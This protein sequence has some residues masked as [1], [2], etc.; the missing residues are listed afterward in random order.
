[1]SL[2]ALCVAVSVASAMPQKENKPAAKPDFNREV[3]PILSQNCFK[4]HGPD[5]KQRAA[6]L[7]L[8]TP[9]GGKS[10]F[11]RGE[12]VRRILATDAAQMP[13]SHTN[14]ILT[15]TQKETLKRWVA[16]GAN[17][18]PHWAFVPPK[19]SAPNA[20][21]DG[22]VQAHMAREH[23][24]LSPEADRYT[25]VRRLSL[26]LIGLPPTPEETDAFVSDTSAG[27]YEKLVDRLLASP[28]YGEK[29]ARKWLDLARYADTNG[30][31]K[32]R[33]RTMYLYRD[34]VIN[35]LNADMP[36][37]QFTIKQLAGD[38]LS[39]ASMSDK[40]ATGFHRNTM[41]NEE[42]G[43]D[44]L[45]FRFYSM[46]DRVATTGTT[47]L[48][49]TVGCA[50]CH[51]HKF[52]PITHTD[53]YRFLALMNN[54]DEPE[55]EVESADNAKKRQEILAQIAMREADLPRRFPVPSTRVF[56]PLTPQS[57]VTTSG[58][59]LTIQSDGSLLASGNNPETDTYTVAL[60]APD[61]AKAISG[62]RLE[63][64]TDVSLGKSGPGRTPHGNFVLTEI[65]GEVN[66]VA[67][68]LVRA[69]ADF[70][71]EGFLPAG[72][73]DKSKN[74]G[75]AISG[76]G[77]WNVN[78]TAL[79]FFDTPLVV[80]G[81]AKITL[82]LA[83]EYGGQH[84]LGK[85]RLSFIEEQ[86]DDAQPIETQRREAFENTFAAWKTEKAKAATHW[87]VLKPT[88]ARS[89]IPHLTILPDHSVI[90]LGDMSKRDI[91]DVQFANV[92]K[93]ITA[94]RLEAL[95]D[96]R[97][98]KGGPG[99]IFY[100]GTP[101]NFI[102]SELTLETGGKPLPFSRAV[103]TTGN[104]MSAMDNN[105]LTGWSAG[106]DSGQAQVA[107]FRLKEPLATDSFAL[108]M[109]FEFYY[110][111]GLG[112]FRV[113]V[114]TDKSN[115]IAA[116]P[117]QVETLLALPVGKLTVGQD[118]ELRR[119]FCQTTPTLQ[120]EREAI[121]ALRQT[122]PSN[123]TALVFS[124]RP[125]DNPRTTFRQHRGEFLQPKERVTPATFSFL[126]N[127]AATTNRLAFARWLVS[128]QNPLTAR[129]IVNRQWAAFFGRG[130]VP[131]ENDFGYQGD[132]PSHPELLDYL[133][134]R[135]QTPVSQSGQAGLG[136]S[137]KK[138]HKEI[139][140]S[141]TYKQASRSTP[142]A[143]KSDPKN[144]LLARGPRVRLDA[145]LIRDSALKASGLLS[146][147]RGGPSV[148]PPQKPNITTEGAYGPLTWTVSTGEDRYRRGLYT[149][150]KRTAP[151]AMF[152]TFD[153]GSGEA[154]LARRDVSNT[155]LQALT[156]LNNEV[157]VEA[158]QALGKSVSQ[159]AGT[160]S[161]KTTYLFRRVL[162]R[163][164]TLA[165]IAQLTAFYNTQLARLEKKE[166]SAK[167]L[168]GTDD[169]K[170]AAWTTLARA[171]LNLDEAIVKR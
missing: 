69:E 110:A 45:E 34:W 85:F 19:P 168:C 117:A 97:L 124:E 127:P 8:D 137:L 120:T 37:D 150:A 20:S 94:I 149:F 101:G 114:T 109:L 26:D 142:S 55:I 58:A 160:D 96:A 9:T 151:Y 32:D 16:S 46:T 61:G 70:S 49:L 105:P 122:I 100:E 107:V 76:A 3:R 106:G 40:I 89:E 170:Q 57:G 115:D 43:I 74:T 54:A 112:R 78:R 171:L 145:E 38:M 90:A 130:I 64:L 65:S 135:F 48:G 88:S 15:T 157:F 80:P 79:F 72:A 92:P 73:L 147:K 10:V 86:R 166:L 163:P 60:K 169:T 99:R 63:A 116:F 128:G 82:K 50:Q 35:A 164:P 108:K 83:Q 167:A 33:P 133:A 126:P 119:Y 52:D 87:T 129:V 7:R 139:V 102:L 68:K 67:L 95:P 31:E 134:V 111:C 98:P 30:Y 28:H 113:S 152:T 12:F 39:S 104:V 154:C 1:M 131:T 143:E 161:D 21:I 162:T 159:R 41:L 153:A 14:K 141:A 22:F 4:C 155:P 136:W 148:F 156:L 146:D 158:A 59:T 11:A 62:L 6:G 140:M 91:Y 66:G 24:S 29:W 75:W 5:E 18:A 44:P 42:G 118:K 93:S 36:F 25:L 84:T 123:P 51:T 47:W 2:V 165:E 53:Y 81:G 121:T 13:P 56:H 103:A 132:L 138:L 71:Q 77:N 17:Y 23:L 144:I 27:A 125:A